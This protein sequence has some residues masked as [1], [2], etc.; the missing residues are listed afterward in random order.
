MDT[1]RDGKEALEKLYAQWEAAQER[2]AAA[3]AS[4]A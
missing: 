4:V 3:T 1:H 2:L